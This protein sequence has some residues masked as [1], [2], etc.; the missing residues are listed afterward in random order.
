MA[1][2]FNLDK[3]DILEVGCAKRIELAASDA[4]LLLKAKEELCNVDGLLA[5]HRS[6]VPGASGCTNDGALHEAAAT[7]DRDEI[8]VDPE[9][10]QAYTFKALSQR[11]EDQY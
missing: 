7:M 11:Y 2:K 9:D 3:A 10:G 6:Q 8:R 1:Q 4:A 5:Y